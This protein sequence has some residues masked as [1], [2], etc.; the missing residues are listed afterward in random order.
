VSATADTAFE[1]AHRLLSAG[2]V[3]L[4]FSDNQFLCGG[5]IALFVVERRRAILKARDGM[6]LIRTGFPRPAICFI[7]F[8]RAFC[9]DGGDIVGLGPSLLPSAAHDRDS[10]EYSTALHYALIWHH[11]FEALLA[12]TPLQGLY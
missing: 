3:E 6:F 9:S 7:Y 8:S 12:E 4:R 5:F 11:M 1:L 2:T 10:T